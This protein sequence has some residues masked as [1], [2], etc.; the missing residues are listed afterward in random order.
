[1]ETPGQYSMPRKMDIAR[2]LMDA[3][4]EQPVFDFPVPQFSFAF[5][6]QDAIF[7]LRGICR[8]SE[9]FPVLFADRD[10]TGREALLDAAEMTYEKEEITQ[11]LREVA[12]NASKV[13]QKIA[14][15]KAL[16]LAGIVSPEVD[17]QF[18]N[19]LAANHAMLFI[20]IAQ[21]IEELSAQGSVLKKK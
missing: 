10:E 5:Q 13:K 7:K 1:M 21:K 3:D 2:R 20:A 18:V 8:S 4:F 12:Y 11:A 17:R 16:C 14:V 6:E 19:W 9:Y 15:Y